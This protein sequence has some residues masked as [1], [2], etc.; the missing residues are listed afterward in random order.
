MRKKVISSRR[1]LISQSNG[2]LMTMT[3]IACLLSQED[4]FSKV[5]LLVRELAKMTHH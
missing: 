2:S 4:D 5:D 1:S 3:P